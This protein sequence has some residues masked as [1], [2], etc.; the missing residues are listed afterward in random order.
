[1]YVLGLNHAY[2]ES[3]ACLI[4]D[5][6]VLA[7]AEEE[8]FTRVKHAKPALVSNPHELPVHAIAYCL[9]RAG[10]TLAQVDHIGSSIDPAKR[11]RNKDFPDRIVAGDWGSDIGETVFHDNLRQVP[12]QLREMSFGGE[13][14]WLSHH[15][16]HGASAYYPSPFADAAVLAVDGIGETASTLLACGQ[17]IRL[18]PI[19]EISYPA[20]IGFLWEKLAQFLGFSEYD[21]SK[22]MGLAAYGD[23]EPY[24]DHFRQILT[25]LPNGRFAIDNDLLRFRIAD[26]SSLTKL[27]GIGP[28]TPHSEM[29]S[30]Y[31]DIT[32]A[33]Q[34]ATDDTMVHL[35]THAARHLGTRNLCL[36]GGVALNCVANAHIA[37]TGLFDN[38]YIQPAAHDGGTALGAALLIWHDIL[39]RAERDR[40]RHAQLGPEYDDTDIE[41]AL[42]DSCLHYRRV[43]DITTEVARLLADQKIVGW[44]Q[45]R[46]EFGPRA[47]GNRSLLADP[48]Q[49]GMRERLNRIVKK[50]EDFRPFAPS[51]LAEEAANWFDIP[52]PCQASD[53][54]LIGY[55]AL[56]PEKIPAVVHVD[57]TSRIQTVHH[58]HNPRY[59]R[60]IS[61]FHR[62]TGIPLVLNT[63]YNDREPIVCTPTDAITTLRRTGIDYLAIGNFLAQ[64]TPTHLNTPPTHDQ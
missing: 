25:L 44:F 20:S 32:A 10:I 28:R 17:G 27:F 12:A 3:A 57:G 23:P 53:F 33:L 38:L 24:R 22:V 40:M 13:F 59:H 42:R 64:P 14:H 37:A 46:M 30:T 62:I 43:Q 50:R 4:H 39:G 35:A 58:D 6:R 60:L 52:L 21:A 31:A 45:G 54:M 7:A 5:G 9:D 2:H 11:L 16:C 61:E 63:S 49:P 18:S 48:R 15:L 29:T 19:D 55:R 34:A 41:A 26:Y 51:V 8:R 47:L 56:T 1:M 36:A